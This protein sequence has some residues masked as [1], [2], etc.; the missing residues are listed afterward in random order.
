MDAE[1]YVRELERTRSE[2]LGYNVICG[3]RDA[4]YHYSNVSGGITRLETGVHGVSN[5]LL[6]TPWPKVLKGVSA[7]E[8]LD[9][10]EV[11]DAQEL[12]R[13]VMDEERADRSALPRDTGMSEEK[14]WQRSSLF[15]NAPGYATR[16][17]TIV[18]CR[19]DGTIEFTER[20]HFPESQEV[21]FRV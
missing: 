19:A 9:S 4:L 12:L 8:S 15:V 13:I 20:T 7:I 18:I 11:P 1:S 16:T 10:T 6:N 3:D 17:S 14:E 2:Y 5:A 21:R